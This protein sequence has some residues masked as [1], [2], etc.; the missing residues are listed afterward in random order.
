MKV[1][2]L[3]ISTN[4]GWAILENDHLL[5]YGL[6]QVKVE[7]FNVAQ[8]PEKDPQYPFNMVHSADKMAVA[9]IQLY[10]RFKPGYVVVDNTVKG[11][12]RHT[13][14]ILEFIHKSL[15]DLFFKMNIKPIYMDPSQWRH[16]LDI[17][18]SKQDKKNN[19]LVRQG[20]KRG[21][22][23]KKHLS[24]RVCNQIFNTT[25]KIKDNNITDSILLGLAFYKSGIVK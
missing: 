10:Y 15:L 6:I 11:R 17:K 21:T 16:L 3:D 14:R 7:N 18:L 20:K 5:D 19:K 22:I 4:T 1:L 24:V 2:A 12:N 9:I 13:Q 23:S 8:H 25:F